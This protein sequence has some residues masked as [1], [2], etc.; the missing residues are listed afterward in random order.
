MEKKFEMRTVN[1]AKKTGVSGKQTA[2]IAVVYLILILSFPKVFLAIMLAAVAGGLILG[3]YRVLKRKES[4]EHGS[5][6]KAET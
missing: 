4:E 5:N 3:T 2:L 1:E 6:R